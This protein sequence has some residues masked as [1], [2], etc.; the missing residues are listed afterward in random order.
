MILF[1]SLREKNNTHSSDFP[2]MKGEIKIIMAQFRYQED[3]KVMKLRMKKEW[4]KGA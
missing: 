2:E 4:G 3:K 1:E